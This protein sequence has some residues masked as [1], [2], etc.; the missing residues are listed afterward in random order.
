MKD[1][2]TLPEDIYSL[3]DSEDRIDFSKLGEDLANTFASRIKK[4]DGPRNTLRLSAMGRCPRALWYDFNGY[5]P[6]PLTPDTRMKF[7]FG[8]V[9]EDMML[10]FAEEAGHEV[11]SRQ[12]EVKV[13]GVTGHIDAIIDGMLIDVKSASSY[14]FKKFKKGK[15]AE[16]DAFGY[17][18]QLS[19]YLFALQDD[20]DLVVK[21]KAAFL[22]VDK[23]HGHICLDVHEI[24]VS[25]VEDT[26]RR[27]KRKVLSDEIPERPY[28]LIKEP[29]GNLKLPLNCSYCSHKRNCYP[30]L[31][32]FISSERPVFY[33]KVVKEPKMLE[34]T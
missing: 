27:V 24:D 14:S 10:S 28:S 22:V 33:A 30:D 16:D 5:D 11:K 26:I 6:E 18:S 7:L 17:I 23:Q 25:K 15:L 34:V 20:P 8:D 31:R 21:D 32:V 2:N 1:I 9:L 4:H 13:A 12:K 19:S 3:F 29:R